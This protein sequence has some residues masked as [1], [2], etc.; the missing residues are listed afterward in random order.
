MKKTI[1]PP[2]SFRAKISSESDPG[3][4]KYNEDSCGQYISD[5]KTVMVFVT[6]DGLGGH[7]GGKQASSLA[8]NAILGYFQK[9]P[10]EESPEA[11]LRNSLEQ[12]NQAIAEAAGKDQKLSR[13]KTTAV[14]LFIKDD[15]AYWAHVGD[16]RLYHIRDNRVVFRTTDHSVVQFLVNTGEITEAEMRGHPDRNRLLKVLGGNRTTESDLSS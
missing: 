9:H 5:D 10:T 12:A 14:I 8:V 13:M 1:L 15:K 11:L 6:A 7:V 2:A 3:G 16:S 4:R